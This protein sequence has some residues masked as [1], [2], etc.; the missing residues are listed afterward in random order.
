MKWQ[1]PSLGHA[2][3]D[4]DSSIK[5]ISFHLLNVHASGICVS[6]HACMTKANPTV[7]PLTPARGG[8]RARGRRRRAGDDAMDR[9]SGCLY[10]LDGAADRAGGCLDELAD[11]IVDEAGGD[12]ADRAGG[13]LDELADGV[14]DEAGDDA[15][16]RAGGRL[17]ELAD[18]VVDEAGDAQQTPRRR[19]IARAH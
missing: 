3:I 15:A 12:A 13:R 5:A 1:F 16:D 14:V 6:L 7:E 18:G 9:A 17:Y 19:V 10:V 4:I 11:G 2:L 8:G